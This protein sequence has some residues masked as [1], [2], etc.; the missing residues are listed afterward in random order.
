M[1]QNKLPFVPLLFIC[2]LIATYP[3]L[4]TIIEF[5]AECKLAI[6]KSAAEEQALLF[7]FW[8]NA[9]VLHASFPSFLQMNKINFIS[10]VKIVCN[11]KI[12]M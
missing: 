1:Y 3:T 10:K 6:I 5:L 11:Y 9:E 7:G 2:F 12:A 4:K 8:S